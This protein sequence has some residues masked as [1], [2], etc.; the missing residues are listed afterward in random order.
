MHT[1]HQ[2]TELTAC[3]CAHAAYDIVTTASVR[4][5]LRA[6]P[7]LELFMHCCDCS[8][9]DSPK[10]VIGPLSTPNLVYRPGLRTTAPHVCHHSV[11]VHP[12]GNRRLKGR[13]GTRPHDV[14][15]I[16]PRRCP[17]LPPTQQRSEALWP[18]IILYR[19]ICRIVGEH[20]YLA[21]RVLCGSLGSLQKNN[22]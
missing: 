18:C 7:E 5:I 2:L 4:Q 20:R 3:C 10:A 15:L 9:T 17:L 16:P 19:Q 12:P 8:P 13:N 11:S 1:R 14:K 22:V 6:C 21:L